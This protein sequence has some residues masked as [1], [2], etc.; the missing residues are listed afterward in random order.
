MMILKSC[1]VL[2]C[3]WC[4]VNFAVLSGVFASYGDVSSTLIC[5]AGF[6][7]TG[8]LSGMGIASIIKRSS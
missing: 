2:V 1:A 7:S 5:L 8:I 3:M 6:I 4:A